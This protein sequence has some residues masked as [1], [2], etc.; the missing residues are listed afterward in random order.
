MVLLLAFLVMLIK[1]KISLYYTT[2]A[3]HHLNYIDIFQEP[4]IICFGFFGWYNKNFFIIFFSLQEGTCDINN[5]QFSFFCAINASIILRASLEQ[6][7]ESFNISS[8]YIFATSRA[9][10]IIIN[11]FKRTN[12][13]Q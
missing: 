5:I 8:L 9:F 6:V 3:K 4:N 11:V 12:T 1:G 10:I 2:Y 13:F 7:G